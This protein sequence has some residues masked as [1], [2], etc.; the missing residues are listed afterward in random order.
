MS[1][2]DDRP[3]PLGWRI[4]ARVVDIVVFSWLVVIV[5][6]EIDQRL[7]GGDPLGRRAVGLEID[8]A[9]P[10]ALLALLVIGYEIVPVA[11]AGVTPG[12]LLFGMRLRRRPDDPVPSLVAS[13]VRALLLYLPVM[14]AAPL[15]GV[16][17]LPLL[18]SVVV[19]ADGRGLHDRRAGTLVVSVGD[20]QTP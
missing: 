10:V 2:L 12:K 1:D 6:V 5:L 14:V 18:V 19:S 15:G 8:A 9:R 7:L 13:F 11:W 16:V 20:R 3:A 4:G 17:L